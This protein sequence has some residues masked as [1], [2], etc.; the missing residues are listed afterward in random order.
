M[1]GRSGKGR[2]SGGT[3]AQPPAGEGRGAGPPEPERERERAQAPPPAGEPGLTESQAFVDP[4]ESDVLRTDSEPP[5]PPELTESQ[6]LV[7]LS[8]SDVLRL[9]SV[10]EPGSSSTGGAPPAGPRQDEQPLP[11]PPELT[12]S[13][14]FV[15]LTGSDVRRLEEAGAAPPA[16][17]GPP[18]GAG[19]AAPGATA[20][21]GA[22]RGAGRPPRGPGGAGP[23]PAPAGGG[24]GRWR[25]VLGALWL[26]SIGLAWWAGTG[27]GP[28]G[29]RGGAGEGA[30]GG[31]AGSGFARLVAERDR[32][33]AGW[34]RAREELEGALQAQRAAAARERAQ[35]RAELAE[36]SR[37]RARA[38]DEL[39]AARAAWQQERQALAAAQQQALAEQRRALQAELAERA[40]R[41]RLDLERQVRD[42]VA[43]YEALLA[44][45]EAARDKFTDLVRREARAEVLRREALA[46]QQLEQERAALQARQ[47]E[48]LEQQ[49]RQIEERLRAELA[50]AGG[51]G[52]AAG[53]LFRDPFAAG[54][55][56][57]EGLDLEREVWDH[58]RGHLSGAAT[59]R[60]YG[61][62]ER[63]AA[64][65]AERLLHQGRLRLR[66]EVE[67][68]DG[69]K[70]HL[71]PELLLDDGALGRGV[72]RELVDRAERRPILGLEE[73]YLAASW[74][75]FDLRLGER[76][77]GWGTGDLFNPTDFIN[78]LDY[79]DLFDSEKIGVP[80]L[81]AVWWPGGGD[82][83]VM[84]LW[85]PWF[86]PARLPPPGERFLPVPPEQQA[87]LA[88]R[89]LPARTL[90]NSELAL[91][92]KTTLFGD[93]DVSLTLFRGF[94]RLP[95]L[96]V[97]PAASD[98][99]FQLV[100]VFDRR[101]V[102]GADFAKPLAFAPLEGVVLNG[103][104]AQVIT[105]GGRDDDFLTWAIGARRTWYPFDRQLTV[106][107]QYVGEW[108]THRASDPDVVPVIQ[109]LQRA[110]ASSLLGRVRLEPIEQLELTLTGA[111]LLDGPDS[112]YVRPEASYKI[113][114]HTRIRGGLDLA[115]GQEQGFFGLF[116]D[117]QRLFLELTLSF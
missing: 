77:Y 91:R 90:A 58:L 42:T 44:E 113:G 21:P 50:L 18:S 76:I 78:P 99:F 45:M 41:E 109:R 1:G 31:P 7:Y 103:E 102:L 9:D 65:Q 47:Q 54:E 8:E 93:L 100:P 94:H 104:L 20:R 81:E 61:Y 38:E 3:P 105:E 66:Y 46:R 98:P 10:E 13:S 95:N 114:T 97:R 72:Q 28:L 110:F 67:L 52:A 4:S 111:L 53:G 24:R 69:L 85:L 57:A 92:I 86:V 29:L 16:A 71:A 27:G 19:R 107:L 43:R 6:A 40:R 39:A 11:A 22:R 60:L 12:E 106:F 74:G 59:Y 89:R 48:Q 116:E 87:L 80:A 56:P 49:A 36:A 101:V 83:S 17:H 23:A 70:L 79:S 82:T 115:G 37:A 35:L 5:A 25:L 63:G 68:V 2:G 64:P 62:F 55:P 33:L 84:V 26:G 75:E 51:G 108:V 112:W 88:A 117:D 32:A 15:V 73:G 30:G 34:Q 96:V 14:T